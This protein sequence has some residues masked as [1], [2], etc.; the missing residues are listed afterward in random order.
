MATNSA[1]MGDSFG[2]SA[3]AWS[4]E[5]LAEQ[6]GVRPVASLDELRCDIWASDEELDAF[7]A[8]LHASRHADYG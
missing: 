4:I 7:L 8:D 3:D 6:Q 1:D 5:E 2:W